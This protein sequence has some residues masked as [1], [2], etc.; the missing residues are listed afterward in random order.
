M[1]G[2]TGPLQVFEGNKGFMD[3]ITGPFEIDWSR[4]DLERVTRT[5]VKKYN[6]EIHAQSAIEGLLETKQANHFAAADVAHIDIE[7]FDI[8]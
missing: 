1:R 5:I 7:I 2:I 6:A 4:E 3:A 8:D